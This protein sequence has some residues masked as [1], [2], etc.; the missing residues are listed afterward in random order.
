MSNVSDLDW[1]SALANEASEHNEWREFAAFAD[2]RSQGLR[3]EAFRHLSHFIHATRDWKFEERLGFCRW[4]LG[5][6]DAFGGLGIASPQPLRASLLVPT[7]REWLERE[8][9]IAEA[10]LWL[11]LLRCDD[12]S[13][14]LTSALALNPNCQRARRVLVEWI[15]ND[16][17]YNQHELPSFYIQDPRDDLVELE[18]AADLLAGVPN[19]TE[20][21]RQKLEIVELRRRAA[22]WLA[23]HPLPGD[24]ADH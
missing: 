24:F 19:S 20:I 7:M 4:L 23:A 10:H 15:I 17:D 6:G 1:L 16:I 12:P 9:K 18:R 5:K 8:P 14:H 11:G 22:A 21:D 13:E 3:T 2:S